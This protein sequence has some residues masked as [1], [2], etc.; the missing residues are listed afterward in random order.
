MQCPDCGA[1]A[2]NKDL[3]CGE[4]GRP[5]ADLSPAAEEGPPSDLA[6][7]TLELPEDAPPPALPSPP[8]KRPRLAVVWAI[9]AAL[10]ALLCV[11]AAVGVIWFGL[12]GD[13]NA[14]PTAVEAPAGP[15]IYADDFADPDSGWDVYTNDDTWAGYVDGEYRLAVYVN[16]FVTWGNPPADEEIADFEF[17]ADARLVEGPLDNNFGL[18]VRYQADDENYYWFQISSDGYYSVDL[19]RDGEWVGLVGW[20]TSDAIRQ[21]VDVNNHLKVACSGDRFSF[22]VNGTHL[23]SL[24]DDSFA[25]GS[26]GLAAGTFGESGVVVHFDHVQVRQIQE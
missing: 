13:D 11:C 17:E 19:L 7:D 20:E 10:M 22:Y 5:L 8:P 21:G 12:R 1:Y 25:T 26:I 9:A 24:N 15:V 6:P 2:G 16:D 18:L 4:C 23:V 14:G 3:F